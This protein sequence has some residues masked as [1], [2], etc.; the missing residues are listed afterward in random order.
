L[1]IKVFEKIRKIP[2][3]KKITYSFL[4]KTVGKPKSP[5]TVAKILGK[6]CAPIII[7]CHRAVGRYNIGG[8]KYPIYIKQKLLELENK[9]SIKKE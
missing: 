2:Y 9:N 6:N 1:E 4:A 8:F 3:G 7:P 5:R